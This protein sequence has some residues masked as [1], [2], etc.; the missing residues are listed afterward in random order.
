M[1]PVPQVAL[2]SFR[3][4]R[5]CVLAA[6]AV[7][8][9]L[10]FARWLRLL[11]RDR[12]KAPLGEFSA[13]G[14][15]V[16]YAASPQDAARPTP[17]KA[18]R[19]SLVNFEVPRPVREDLIRRLASWTNSKGGFG[20]FVHA[21]RV[22]HFGIRHPDAGV[23][24]YYRY[25][26]SCVTTDAVARSSRGSESLI[27]DTPDGVTFRTASQV[28][29][30]IDSTRRNAQTHVDKVLSVLAELELDWSFPIIS[31]TGTRY[32]L[33]HLFSD[34]LAR[35]TIRRELEWTIIAYSQLLDNEATWK[36]HLGER[37]CFDDL[38]LALESQRPDTGACAGS[39]RLY[40]LAK[41]STHAAQEPTLLKTHTRKRLSRALRSVTESLTASQAPDG[42]WS[43]SWTNAMNGIP[44]GPPRNEI[45]DYMDRF[46]VTSHM[47][48]WFAV[49]QPTERPV[50]SAIR[51][52]AMF[53]GGHLSSNEDL[54]R[55]ELG[56][57]AHGIHALLQLSSSAAL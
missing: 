56:A 24:G 52:A 14:A 15:S 10:G 32:E 50:A 45:V 41:A 30:A 57:C 7:I 19:F 6:L 33:R 42:S 3:R 21:L 39:H 35:A 40:A 54:F 55:S 17:R 20:N 2:K 25:L 18:R 1:D 23:R 11:S 28:K 34:S 5:R 13:G 8:S 26:I 9:G 47:I 37:L 31:R 51:R 44:S 49:A 29:A 16:G 38:V 22:Y 48:E 27:L 12:P 36:N 46:V 53:V 4:G 43:S